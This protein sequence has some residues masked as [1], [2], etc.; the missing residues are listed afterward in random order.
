MIIKKATCHLLLLLFC[1]YVLF[2]RSMIMCKFNI[3]N[4]NLFFYSIHCLIP[5]SNL[6]VWETGDIISCYCFFSV[7][8]MVNMSFGESGEKLMVTIMQLLLL[9]IP[10][11]NRTQL[12]YLL[13]FMN[14]WNLHHSL[15]IQTD[16]GIIEIQLSW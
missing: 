10:V 6:V 3:C 11:Y 16:V 12:R 14:Q 9:C 7:G 8:A 5:T 2:E 4:V 13:H 1:T 15:C